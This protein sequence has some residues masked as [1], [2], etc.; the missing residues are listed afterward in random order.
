ML[1]ELFDAICAKAIEAR[2]AR[3]L[4]TPAEP[5]HHYLVEKPD[6]TLE[7]HDAAPAP[8]Q[9]VVG[10][11]DSLVR[12]AM[13]TAEAGLD[14]FPAVWYSRSGIVCLLDDATR[15]DRVTLPLSLSPQLEAIIDLPAGG[16]NPKALGKMLR[17]TFHDAIDDAAALAKAIDGLKF[18]QGQWVEFGVSREK[19]SVGRSVRESVRGLVEIP[20]QVVLRV[21]IFASGFCEIKGAV[22]CAIEFGMDTGTVQLLPLPGHVEAAIAGAERTIGEQLVDAL[23]EKVPA[24]FGDPK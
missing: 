5:A 9:H 6:G 20:Q 24:Y 16:M 18:E 10:D 3:I 2:S 19:S 8:R 7:P 1:K 15:R 22:T 11:L 13:Q 23:G 4:P 21:P 12:W 17:V 14:E